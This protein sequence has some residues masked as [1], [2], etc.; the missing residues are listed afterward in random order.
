VTRHR[1]VIDVAL[2]G[3]AINEPIAVSPDGRT[4]YYGAM[5]SQSDIWIVEPR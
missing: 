2:P 3:P 1:T 4:I 5:R